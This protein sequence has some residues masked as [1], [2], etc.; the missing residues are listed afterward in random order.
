MA[1]FANTL[2]TCVQNEEVER[3]YEI[4]QKQQQCDEE[5]NRAL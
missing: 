1:V 2:N 4:Q 3:R 5:N